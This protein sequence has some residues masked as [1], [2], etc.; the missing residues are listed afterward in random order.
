MIFMF[1]RKYPNVMMAMGCLFTF[2]LTYV[3]TYTFKDSLPADEG[4]EFAVDGHKS[5]GKPRGA[6][7]IFVL[8]FIAGTLLFSPIFTVGID[9][10]VE[11]LV[12]ILLIF[13]EM[14]T[15]FLDDRANLPWS[16]TKKGLLDFFICLALAVNY[17]YANGSEFKFFTY[18]YNIPLPVLFL[19]IVAF[20]WLSINA[21]NCA[22]GVDGLSGTLTLITLFSFYILDQN[23]AVMGIFGYPVLFFA[24]AVGAYLWFNAGPS[25]LMMGDAGSRSMGLFIFIVALKSG[26]PLLFIPF[27]MVLLLDGG[28][29]LF[30]VSM[31]KITKNRN[32]MKNIRTPLHDHVRKNLEVSWSNNQC[33][34]RFAIIQ[35]AISLVVIF[36]FCL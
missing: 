14:M 22:D 24:S 11:L 9:I 21:T 15:G 4:R 32:F 10:I 35:F 13:L 34:T 26:H 1:L 5:K 29:G 27:A 36:L 31:I 12:Y 16:R 33:V 18:S 30:K 3:C 6:G 7:I 2:L 19:V 8:A 23:Y 25:I 28:L 17:I 20:S